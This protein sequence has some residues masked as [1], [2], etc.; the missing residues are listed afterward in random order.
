MKKHS[1]KIIDRGNI[2]EFE[3]AAENLMDLGYE[4]KQ[5]QYFETPERDLTYVAIFVKV[6][7]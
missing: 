5:F 4:M 6:E 2:P 3:K 7:D 1:V